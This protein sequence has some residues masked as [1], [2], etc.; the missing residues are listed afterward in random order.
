MMAQSAGL[1]HETRITAS[2]QARKEGRGASTTVRQKTLKKYAE[3][4]EKPEQQDKK[5]ESLRHP[6]QGE[7]TN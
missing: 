4:P 6:R 7:T 2:W 5:L 3:K 1:K